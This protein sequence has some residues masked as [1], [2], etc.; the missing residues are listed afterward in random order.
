MG[1]GLIM[2]IK[3]NGDNHNTAPGT[4]G[5]DND[6]GIVYGADQV[7][8]VTGGVERLNVGNTDISITNSNSD[9]L[10][11]S[12]DSVKIKTAGVDRIVTDTTG[13]KIASG[14]S[15]R[16]VVDN[17]GNIG[18]GVTPTSTTGYTTMTISGPDYGSTIDFKTGSNQSLRI[19]GIGVGSSIQQ[20]GNYPIKFLTNGTEKAQIQGGGGISFN[21]DTA[22]D[23]ALNDYEYGLWTPTVAGT[24]STGT[25][26]YTHQ[27]GSYIK[28]GHTV[29]VNFYVQWTSLNGTGSLKVLGAPFANWTTGSPHAY[30]NLS[31]GSCFLNSLTYPRWSP[32][33]YIN[34]ATN[35]VFY[36]SQS[37]QSWAG[38]PVNASGGIIG[39][40]EYITDA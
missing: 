5:S 13:V 40:I 9:S 8:I 7:K 34:G 20:T 31:P 11:V 29:K 22:T 24:T 33:T 16:L 28:I 15:D 17:N 3:I 25:A 14:G 18:I 32:V 26:S 39:A 10:N 6:S 19:Q 38:V 35:I 12:S 30:N 1:C 4:G 21:G 2:T 23:N 37:G 36:A 27:Y